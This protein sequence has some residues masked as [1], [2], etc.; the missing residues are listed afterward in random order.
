VGQPTATIG[1]FAGSRARQGLLAVTLG[2]G[3][4]AAVAAHFTGP[5]ASRSFASV[6]GV[7]Q[8]LMSVAVPL[9]GILLVGDVRRGPRPAR[10]VPA[11]LTAVSLAAAVGVVG[12][13]ISAVTLLLARETATDPWARAGTIAV[14]SVLVQVVAVLVGSG[15]GLLIRSSVLAFIAT[16]VLPLALWFALGAVGAAREWLTP[17]AAAQNL[18]SG[19][20]TALTWAQW[21]VVAL[22]WGVGLNAL[23]AARLKRSG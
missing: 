12:I 9:I 10:L 22:L 1:R 7:V 17:Y 18:L 13:V 15:L 3:L 23:G 6:S 16:I 4:L 20:M 14:G 11:W 8:S 2:L 5:A 21:C 19:E